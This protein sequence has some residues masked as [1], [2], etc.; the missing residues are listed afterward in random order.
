M[1]LICLVEKS[2]SKPIFSSLVRSIWDVDIDILK[3]VSQK[4]KK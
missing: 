2:I 4:K 3:F 1:D